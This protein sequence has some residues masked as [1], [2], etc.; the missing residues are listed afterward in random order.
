MVNEVSIIQLGR[1]NKP[2]RTSRGT[3]WFCDEQGQNQ[4]N[5]MAAS[6]GTFRNRSCGYKNVNNYGLQLE[7]VLSFDLLLGNDKE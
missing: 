4:A 5:N 6:M 1:K 2:R 7:D 3:K